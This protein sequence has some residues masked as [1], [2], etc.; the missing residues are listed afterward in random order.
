MEAR[1][2]VSWGGPCPDGLNIC[3]KNGKFLGHPGV[4]KSVVLLRLRSLKIVFVHSYANVYQRVVSTRRLLLLLD[5]WELQ[6]L[7]MEAL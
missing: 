7:K 6:D 5:Q 1:P 3:G 2:H 4:I